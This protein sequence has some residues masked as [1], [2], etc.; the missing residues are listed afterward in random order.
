[1]AADSSHSDQKNDRHNGKPWA[2]IFFCL[3]SILR[4]LRRLE[5]VAPYPY[6]R[7]VRGLNE[8]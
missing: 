6:S 1:M 2:V 5:A 7:A 4:R 8:G 3:N